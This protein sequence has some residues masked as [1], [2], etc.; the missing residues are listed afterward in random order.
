VDFEKVLRA[1]RADKSKPEL[2]GKD[3]V[4]LYTALEW[5]KK[6]FMETSAANKF[7]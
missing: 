3:V 6:D 7:N 4:Q 1:G 5:L 2:Q